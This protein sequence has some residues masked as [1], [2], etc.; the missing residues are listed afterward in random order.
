MTTTAEFWWQPFPRDWSRPRNWR[1]W[2][3]WDAS[4]VARA[5][6]GLKRT[7]ADRGRPSWFEAFVKPRSASRAAL[8]SSCAPPPVQRTWWSGCSETCR[9]P[10]RSSWPKSTSRGSVRYDH[11]AEPAFVSRVQR[12]DFLPSTR[13]ASRVLWARS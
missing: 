13:Q 4:R 5:I 6:I 7:L 9:A 3:W 8:P 2:L 11:G 12:P 10:A 1:R